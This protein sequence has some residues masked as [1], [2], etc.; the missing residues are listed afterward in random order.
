M[1]R[2]LFYLNWV[3]VGT[4]LIST[5]ISPQD[6]LLEVYPFYTTKL[7]KKNRPIYFVEEFGNNL[8]WAFVYDIEYV[9][10]T[11]CCVDLGFC[12]VDLMIKRLW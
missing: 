7:P 10:S 11:T 6:A 9:D 4:N 2:L 3:F 5:G 1:K 8:F 12:K